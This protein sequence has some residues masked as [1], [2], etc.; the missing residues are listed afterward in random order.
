VE[1]LPAYQT[2]LPLIGAARAFNRDPFRSHIAAY[3][4]CGPIY[5]TRI[6]AKE[7]VV[8][9]GLDANELVWRNTDY[10]S[11]EDAN[12]A[13]G[14]QMGADHVT[15]LDGEPH[16]RRRMHLKPAF[17]MDSIMRHVPTMDRVIAKALA[18]VT[19]G[20]FD[21]TEFLSDLLI[22]VSSE[23]TLQCDLSDELITKMNHWERQFLFGIGLGWQRHLFYARPSYRKLKREV[24]AE[25]ARILEARQANAS[26]LPADNLTAIIQAN[27]EAGSEPLTRWDLINDIYLTLLAGVHNTANLLY[28][29]LVYLATHRDWLTE[30]REEVQTWKIG[31]FRGMTPWPKLKATIQEVQRLRPGVIIHR[32]TAARPFDFKGYKIPNGTPILHANSLAHFLEEIYEDPFRFNPQRF[33]GGRTYPAKA[34]GFFGGGTHICL[35]MNLAMVHTPLILANLVRDYDFEFAFDPSF[36]V[37]MVTGTNQVR[38][39]VPI[40]LR[41]RS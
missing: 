1:D 7:W 19:Q 4:Q 21:L 6:G 15:Q 22:K 39:N 25:F 35:G 10:W 32:L 18:G 11:Y 8:L 34:N 13:F 9:A 40:G 2:G 36:A 29:C 30:L 31:E 24:F 17:R 20:T 27:D 41:K 5:R 16:K 14:E 23:T 38:K 33:L 28:W 12:A 3:R 37:R 26:Q